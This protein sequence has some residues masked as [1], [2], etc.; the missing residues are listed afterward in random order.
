MDIYERLD[1]LD[2]AT[3]ETKAARIL[4]GLGEPLRII[5]QLNQLRKEVLNGHN[6]SSEC[7]IT[8]ILGFS[9]SSK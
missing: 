2:A 4:H 1:E 6:L 7:L 8:V 5:H 3:A 9:E